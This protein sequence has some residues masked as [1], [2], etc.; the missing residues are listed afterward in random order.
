M[1]SLFDEDQREFIYADPAG[2]LM[3]STSYRKTASAATIDDIE[4]M[5]RKMI[6]AAGKTVADARKQ[7]KLN[8]HDINEFMCEAYDNVIVEFSKYATKFRNARVVQVR[9]TTEI[10]YDD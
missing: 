4:K 3:H 6:R 8:S 10:S 5:R 7:L 2:L 1:Y 9:I